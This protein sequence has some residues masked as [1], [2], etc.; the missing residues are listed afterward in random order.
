MQLNVT[1]KEANKNNYTIEND[2]KYPSMMADL[3]RLYNVIK[4]CMNEENQH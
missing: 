3:I 1:S 2:A 4:N